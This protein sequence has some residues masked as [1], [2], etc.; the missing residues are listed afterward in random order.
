M[1][2]LILP[3]NT[4]PVLDGKLMTRPWYAFFDEMTRR[5]N[6]LAAFVADLGASPTVEQISTAFNALLEAL[7]DAEMQE[8]S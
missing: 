6:T 7:Q 8:T 5:Q 2:K 1:A 3:H 4:T